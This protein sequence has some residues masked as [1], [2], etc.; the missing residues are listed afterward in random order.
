MLKIEYLPVYTRNRNQ[1]QWTSWHY[2]T[3][4]ERCLTEEGE[5]LRG[6]CH[7]FL[8]DQ[9]IIVDI[10]DYKSVIAPFFAKIKAKRRE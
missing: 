8:S 7:D 6:R 2:K 5:W 4:A 10:E 1:S 9:S 3:K